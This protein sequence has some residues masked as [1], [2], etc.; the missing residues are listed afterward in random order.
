MDYP[1]VTIG[2]VTHNGSFVNFSSF[3]TELRPALAR[4]PGDCQLVMVNN[5][6]LDAVA[7]TKAAVTQSRIDENA[8]CLVTA[9]Y[10]N[11]I[12]IGRNTV[13]EQAHHDLVALIDDDEFPTP[14]WL[15]HLVDTQRR[16][17]CAV[18]AGPALPLYL[19]DTPRWIKSL[20][21]HSAKGKKTDDR[22]GNCPTANVLIDRTRIVGALFNTDFGKSGGE[23]SEFFLRQQDANVDMRWSNEAVVYEYIPASKSTSLYMMKRCVLQGA[24]NRR[25]LTARGDIPSQ[26]RFVARSVAVFGGSLILGTV[27]C[28]LGHSRSGHWLQRAFGNLGHCLSY[29]SGLYPHA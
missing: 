20:D 29:R 15:S 22:I 5:S 27:L 18:V 12:A 1:P 16:N 8:D 25:I 28:V 10:E 7:D 4:Y 23:D 19:F 11:N 3:L 17:G 13:F 14:D 6:G 2:V 26:P 9:S 24:L 21:L